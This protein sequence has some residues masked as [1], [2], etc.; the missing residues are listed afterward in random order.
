MNTLPDMIDT[1]LFDLDGT[2]IDSFEAFYQICKAACEAIDH[3]LPERTALFPV[4]NEGASF[5]DLCF[6]ADLPQ[7][8]SVM[9]A[10]IQESQRIRLDYLT[11]YSQLMPDAAELIRHLHRSKYKLGIITSSRRE[12][13]A[14]LDRSQLTG[15][16][17]VIVTKDDV[18]ELKPHPEGVRLALRHL[19]SDPGKTLMVGD[20]PMDVLAGKAS[21]TQTAGVLSSTENETALINTIPDMLFSSLSELGVW[22]NMDASRSARTTRSVLLQADYSEGLGK[23]SGFLTI[24]WVRSRIEAITGFTPYPGTFN[25]ELTPAS[26]HRLQRFQETHDRSGHVFHSRPGFCDALLFPCRL[27]S[28]V[29]ETHAFVLFPMVPDYPPHKLEIVAPIQLARHLGAKSNP[30]LQIEIYL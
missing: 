17:D 26:V 10:F 14:P 8:Q 24:D 16:F 6:P 29:S 5:F 7:R 22:L 20:T 19:N 15:Y 11:R 18:A 21:G 13:L 25:L 30:H 27:Q 23:A 4:M 9:D 1:V 12:A 28:R 3:P 2:L